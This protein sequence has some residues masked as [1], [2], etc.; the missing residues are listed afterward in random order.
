[1]PDWALGEREVA[2]GGWSASLARALT[3]QAACVVVV[4]H[5]G[6]DLGLMPS[7]YLASADRLRLMDAHGYWQAFDG[8]LASCGVIGRTWQT[9]RRHHIREVADHPD[10]VAAAPEVAEELCVPLR[11]RGQVVGALNVEALRALT[12]DE[13]AQVDAAAE[14]L[15]ARLDDLG[16]PQESPAQELSRRVIDLVRLAG[17]GDR[18]AV[19]QAVVATARSLSGLQTALLVVDEGTGLRAVAGTGPASG[20][21]SMLHAEQFAAMATWVSN[22]STAYTLGRDEGV[23]FAGHEPLTE[24][25]ART[26]V[27]IPLPEAAGSGY[28]LLVDS[29]PVLL[30]TAAVSLLELLAAQVGSCLQVCAAL[31]VL[32]SRAESDGLTSLGHHAAFQS[33]FPRQRASSGEGKLAVFY[34]DVDHFKAVN[35][36]RG[37]AAGDALLVGIASAL[38][39]A[40]RGKDQVFRIGG[41]EFAALARVADEKDAL[42]LGH[43]LAERARVDTGASL[44]VGVAV[45]GPEEPDELILA[46]ADAALY[47]VKRTGRGEVR[48]F[49]SQV[50]ATATAAS[51]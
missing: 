29:A 12:D 40:L 43:R 11:C 17:E 6:D 46:R 23:R 47:D 44:S 42:A 15:S 38:R 41:D 20:E 16:I 50:P 13:V 28:F 4:A 30:D 51:R 27:V 8:M 7:V 18:V 1:V 39:H 25:G 33:A 48:L 22:G 31:E 45:A 34:L 24:A 26:V 2:M 21:I 14:A 9:G 5:L 3:P 19:E 32:R 35:D 10:Y 49:R 37:H 36:T